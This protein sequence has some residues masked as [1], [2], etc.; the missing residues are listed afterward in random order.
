MSA[1]HVQLASKTYVSRTEKKLAPGA[2]VI[3]NRSSRHYS[4]RILQVVPRY[5][6]GDIH[7]P[8]LL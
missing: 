5:R 7:T 8:G 4:R 3:G 1:A 6:T 2:A